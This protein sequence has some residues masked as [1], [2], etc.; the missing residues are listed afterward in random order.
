[1]NI[2]DGF[3]G[4][5]A[6][7]AVSTRRALERIPADKMDWRPH[8]KS[9]TLQRLASHVAEIPGWIPQTL[10][11]DEMAMTTGEYKPWLAASPDEL[12]R[13]FDECM[14]QAAKAMQGYPNERMLAPWTFKVDG[15]VVMALP[16]IAA[17][18]G[19]VMNH[20]IHH[21]A[22]LGVYL[23]MIDVPVPQMY[24]PTADEPE[25]GT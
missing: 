13:K 22:Q 19:F 2:I 12:V 5:L 20:L 1:M 7:E 9:M 11:K 14:A 23:R 15:R 10:E 8:T 4:E 6:H 25:M 3:S 18:R 24:G 16:R 17:L 21:R